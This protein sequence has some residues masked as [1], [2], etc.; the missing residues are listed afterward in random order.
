MPDHLD[1][2]TFGF[3]M[4]GGARRRGLPD[5]QSMKTHCPGILGGSSSLAVELRAAVMA[6]VESEGSVLLMGER[7]V[8]KERIARFIHAGSKA[9]NLPFEAVDCSRSF[10]DELEGVLLR[11][12]EGSAGG[13]CYL[14]RCEELSLRLQGRLA[15]YL[16]GSFPVRLLLSS[17]RNLASFTRAGLYSRRLFEGLSRSVIT[18]PP[19]R[20][21][22]RDL[23]SLLDHQACELE[24]SPG[25]REFSPEAFGALAT[26]PW[27][28]NCLQLEAALQGVLR[29]TKGTVDLHDLPA[30]ISGFWVGGAEAA[31]I[32]RLRPH[33]GA[34]VDRFLLSRRLDSEPGTIE[35]PHRN[36][37]S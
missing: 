15:D 36:S 12:K 16:E 2:N 4:P 5:E 21:R 33:F 6:A 18:V 34:E 28:G 8:G 25:G 29:A 30:G 14:S 35:S 20:R 24:G 13:T 31:E 22:M 11:L 9:G 10:E 26:Y 32:N 23:G 19:L 27:P 37:G 3:L 17:P 7:G 1:P